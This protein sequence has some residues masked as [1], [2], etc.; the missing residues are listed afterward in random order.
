MVHANTES[1]LSYVGF[2]ES[3]DSDSLFGKRQAQIDF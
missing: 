2:V 1:G 3:G